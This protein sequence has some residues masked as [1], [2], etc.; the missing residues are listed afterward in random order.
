MGRPTC[1]GIRELP[2]RAIIHPA[3][4]QID[5][6]AAGFQINPS[7][8]KHV[9]LFYIL[10]V[11]NNSIKTFLLCHKTNIVRRDQRIANLLRP[12]NNAVPCS[13]AAR[14]CSL[15][16]AAHLRSDRDPRS[17][18]LRVVKESPRNIRRGESEIGSTQTGRLS[19]ANDARCRNGCHCHSHGF[20]NDFCLLGEHKFY[21]PLLSAHQIHIRRCG[22]LSHPHPKLLQRHAA[23]YHTL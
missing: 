14:P 6:W 23:Q 11:S 7:P 2:S 16:Y 8:R 10:A 19:R 1:L 3:G 20:V 5:G 22:V 12:T 17:E 13:L 18:A 4:D 9:P 15:H 21:T